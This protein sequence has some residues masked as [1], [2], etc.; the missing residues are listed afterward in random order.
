M[1]TSFRVTDKGPGPPGA[2]GSLAW[3]R[4]RKRSSRGLSPEST[5]A[6]SSS[7][8]PEDRIINGSQPTRPAR[9]VSPEQVP[10]PATQPTSSTRKRGRETFSEKKRRELKEA[11]AAAH[12]IIDKREAEIEEFN[13][14]MGR[15]V[16]L[17]PFLRENADQPL[18]E[19]GFASDAEE[20]APPQT[21]SAA[22]LSNKSKRK[23]KEA[24]R[25]VIQEEAAAVTDDSIIDDDPP[26]STLPQGK[27][28]RRDSNSKS[29]EKRKSRVSKG[30][31]DDA[32][33]VGATEEHLN[34]STSIHADES[35]RPDDIAAANQENENGHSGTTTRLMPNKYQSDDSV[36][37]EP[38]RASATD[39]HGSHSDR[40]YAK[41]GGQ[42]PLVP[43]P[44]MGMDGTNGSP[45]SED[46]HHST[47]GDEASE[48][49]DDRVSVVSAPDG[50]LVASDSD[51]QN[52]ASAP[53]S[54]VA[55]DT[56]SDAEESSPPLPRNRESVS[57]PPGSSVKSSRH[58]A[59][60][61][62]KLPF[63][64]RQ[65][66]DNVQA[67]A[68]LP[69]ENAASPSQLRRSTRRRPAPRVEVD[70]VA[71][72][73]DGQNSDGQTNNIGASQ[74][75]TG[76]LSS[77]ERDRVTRAVERFREDEGLTQE[78]INQVIHDN[79][80]TSN[81]PI[82]RQL[83]ATIQDACPFRTRRKLISWCR[84]H[85]H[86]WAGRGTWTQAQDDELADLIEIHGKKWSHIAGLINRY[87]GDVRDR[88]RNYLVCREVVK[89][90]VWSE[91]EEERF[92][93]LVENSIDKIR[94][95]S[96]E[97]SNKAP[98]ELLNW[99]H[100]SEAMGHT[101]S[102]LQCIQKWKRMCEAAPL[103]D[104]VPTV[105][106]PGRS[107]RLEKAREE[108]RRITAEDKY[109]LMCA[110]RDLGVG[111]D[112]K[113]NWKQ[114]V[115]GTFRKRYERQALVV[116]WGRLRKAVPDWQWKATRDCARYLCEM[117]ERE[118]NFGSVDEAEGENDAIAPTNKHRKGKKKSHRLAP[119]D[120]SAPESQEQ[121]PAEME[122]NSDAQLSPVADDENNFASAEPRRK[123]GKKRR[124]AKS[125]TPPSQ[126]EDVEMED[127]MHAASRTK[128]TKSTKNRPRSEDEQNH[129]LD[130]VRRE[131]SPSVGAHAARTRRRERR[132]SMTEDTGTKEKRKGL[133][134][135]ASKAT[136]SK[137]A[138]R[139]R[140]DSLPNGGAEDLGSKKRKMMSLQAMAKTNSASKSNGKSWSVV[141]SDMEDMEDIPA[142]LP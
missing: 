124:E 23:G 20:A 53:L 36:S 108:L 74:Y 28:G 130:T 142:T 46:D 91:G 22:R 114:I 139:P 40:G 30:S 131:S 140:R 98:D 71:E 132:E 3:H 86:N 133:L 73:S 128:S 135:P 41:P 50:S 137:P 12:V 116:T 127:S 2:R 115:N 125:D 123:S 96:G 11:A 21:L 118:G 62:A 120:D 51:N 13:K 35:V 42:G 61:Q 6:T 9:V 66:E 138:K 72:V 100:I 119:A 90:D 97:H 47:T 29:R 15:S 99:L 78:E 69:H 44:G 141:S 84:Q 85:F 76:P 19:F 68:E 113:I 82:H 75:R 27:R 17:S 111:T 117:Y 57:P 102:R 122:S 52:N 5:R 1:P 34:Q 8:P 26:P 83:W 70:A 37:P 60:R 64:S 103:A 7:P 81:R 109:R 94:Q 126:N 38:S 110:V 67:F 87:P 101:R 93:E 106:P 92:R 107:W 58:S 45:H 79:P 31:L 77:S 33:E 39:S 18:D 43:K 88:W 65:Q 16:A 55:S 112:T 134:S 129:Q 48:E 24:I 10:R 121:T 56:G 104:N 49:G 54:P 89:T 32:M 4:R 136:L 25:D 105:L 80:Q 14:R 95:Q 59:K 63:F